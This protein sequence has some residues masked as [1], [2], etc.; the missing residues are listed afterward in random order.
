MF[1]G[2]LQHRATLNFLE[3]SEP[4]TLY[5]EYQFYLDLDKLL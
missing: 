5:E 3:Q 2:A 4:G 1:T